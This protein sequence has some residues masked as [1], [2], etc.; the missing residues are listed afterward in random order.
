[1]ANSKID[2]PGLPTGAAAPDA[3]AEVAVFS[4]R[5]DPGVSWPR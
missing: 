4:A 2:R 3:A 1:M 5:P